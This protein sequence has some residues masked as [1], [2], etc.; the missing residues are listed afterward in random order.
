MP[1]CTPYVDTSVGRVTVHTAATRPTGADRYP[2]KYIFESDTGRTLMWDGTGWV[3]MNEPTQSFTPT[4]GN[5]TIGSPGQSNFGWYQRINGWCWFGAKV[6]LGT[7]GAATGAVNVT[8]PIQMTAGNVS[9]AHFEAFVTDASPTT[10]YPCA[11]TI[12]STTVVTPLSFN[13]AAAASANGLTFSAT[14]PI[15][16]TVGDT[17][18]VG[19]FY[20]MTTRYS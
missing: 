1:I 13:A 11:V 10:F 17:I 18:D 9:N 6:V 2:G 8:L 16:F 15:T 14:V 3:I 20:Q 5:L 19:G 7:G 4:W 12:T